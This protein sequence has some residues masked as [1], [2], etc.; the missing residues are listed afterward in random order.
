MKVL[1]SHNRFHRETTHAAHFTCITLLTSD[2]DEM[3]EVAVDTGSSFD[4]S[5]SLHFC[6][7]QGLAGETYNRVRIIT[8]LSHLVIY[9]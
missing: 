7:R 5:T 8:F 3:N 2:D 6:F 9:C 4:A 1:L